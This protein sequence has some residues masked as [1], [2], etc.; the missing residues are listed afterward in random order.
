MYVSGVHVCCHPRCSILGGISARNPR[1]SDSPQSARIR[2][3]CGGDRARKS[4]KAHVASSKLALIPAAL[5]ARGDIRARFIDCNLSRR[6]IYCINYHALVLCILPEA[7]A[8]RVPT[9]RSR[10]DLN[11]AWPLLLFRARLNGPMRCKPSASQPYLR[12]QRRMETSSSRLNP[13]NLASVQCITGEKKKI[14]PRACI[15]RIHIYIY[16]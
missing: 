16:S 1:T 4:G 14:Y 11:R 15:A 8:P 5:Y 6:Y 13:V 12:I 9:A 10:P 2:E 3:N 7:G